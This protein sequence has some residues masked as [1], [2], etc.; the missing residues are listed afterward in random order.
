MV[1]VILDLP[2]LGQNLWNE[3]LFY[4]ARHKEE[5]YNYWQLLQ[6]FNL[7]TKLKEYLLSYFFF[8][9]FASKINIED[10]S[11]FFKM[12]FSDY[13]KSVWDKNSQN[14]LPG[15]DTENIRIQVRAVETFLS[16][17]NSEIKS[18]VRLEVGEGIEIEKKH[19]RV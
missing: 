7:G 9:E 6:K 18:F 10:C 12:L 19:K 1:K 14:E 16:E 3:I 2:L 4:F 15:I 13:V 11:Q 8:P 17:S 5:E